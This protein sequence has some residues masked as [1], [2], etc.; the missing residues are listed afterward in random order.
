MQFQFVL[1]NAHFSLN[2]FAALVFF[3]VAWLYFDSWFGHKDIKGAYKPFGYLLL[4]LSFVVH[5]TQIEQSL[6]SNPM[7]GLETIGLITAVCRISAYILLIIAQVVDPIMPLP[8]YRRR[9]A[10]M[11]APVAGASAFMDYLPFT[12]PFLSATLAFLYLRRATVGLE[13]HLKPI[14]Y[15]FIIL[16][17]SEVASLAA[18]FR[19]TDIITLANW[20]SAFGPI[21]FLEHVL[22]FAA[23]LVMGRWIWSYLVTRLETQLMMIFT[24]STLAIFLM[25]AVFYT[26]TSL[27]NQR[28]SALKNLETN[29]QVLDYTVNSKKAEVLSDA[30]VIAQN[31]D[32]ISSIAGKDRVRL[33]QL[34]GGNMVAKQQSFLVVV[35]N[36]GEVLIRGDDPEKLGG[37]YSDD[38]LVRRALAGDNVSSIVTREGVL[39]PE[40]SVR[41]ATPVRPDK[42]VIGVVMVGSNIDNAFV[43]GLKKATTLESSVY[44]GNT[45][46]ATTFV[47]A[48][49]KSRWIGIKEE[50]V[51]V[52]QKVL[53]EK[54]AYSGFISILNVPFM[55][56]FSPLEDIEGNSV[57]M[58]FVG[59][60]EVAI[61][62]AASRSIELTFLV[63][64]ALL[65]LSALPSYLI[66]KHIIKQ[67][68]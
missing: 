18:V 56:A 40:V 59:Q 33:A 58:L 16:T 46:S 47:S 25:T 34:T 44:A 11:A 4:C 26:S 67:M 48:D 19:N 14:S 49:G 51:Q 35:S 17:L 50:N 42:E 23:I 21:W 32:V 54:Q 68:T 45:R 63:T 38:P 62:Q 10:A 12:F 66:S 53:N 29:V 65:I 1:I 28:A 9:H 60:P 27:G 24:A 39:S 2:L 20:T 36:S 6:L 52:K 13:N 37:S 8:S 15:S 31:P 43:D 3:A 61:L 41:A 64:A 30:Q 7:L 22:L 5:S 55:A 57:G